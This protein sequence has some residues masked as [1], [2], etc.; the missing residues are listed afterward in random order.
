M[1]CEV[2]EL[3]GAVRGH[4]LFDFERDAF[5]TLEVELTGEFAENVEVVIGEIARNDRVFHEPGFTTFR[6][7]IF[8]LRNGR[9]RYRFPIA[10]HIPAYEGF[11]HCAAPAAAGGEVAPFRYV[12]INRYNGPATVRRTAWF[13]EWN[14]AACSFHSSCEVLNRIWDLCKYSIKATSLFGLYIDGERERMPYEADSYINELSHFCCDADYRLARATIDHF[15][16]HGNFTW[17]TEWLLI[18]PL[19]VREYALYSGDLDSVRQWLETMDEKLLPGYMDRDGLLA[20]AEFAE[21]DA[22]W[23]YTSDGRI[24]RAKIRDI[25]DW[26]QTE[27]DGYDFGT[28]NFVPNAFL[29]GALLTMAELTGKHEYLSRAAALRKAIRSHFMVQGRFVDSKGSVHTALHTAFFALRFGLAEP[30][31]EEAL[32]ALIKE[33]KLACSVYGAQFLLESCYMHDMADY[34][35]ELLTSDAVR[36]W[37]NM[38]RK[39]ATITLESWGDCALSTQ[40]WNHAWGAAPANLIMRYLC[41]IRPVK[42]GFAEWVFE[43]QPAGIDALECRQMTR[44]GAIELKITKDAMELTV[45]PGTTA[46]HGGKRLEP[47]VHK[48]P[49]Q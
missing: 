34:A 23:Y 19:L 30:E 11:P 38:L 43:P 13:G 37:Q 5:S 39:G 40:D 36:S 17:P 47:G 15:M 12:E 22:N 35:L 41:G 33:R 46:L 44:H 27:R 42:P 26:P 9:H 7:H 21:T 48:L 49:R 16:R 4:R 1:P 32:K 3:S 8:K 29:Y 28:V 10:T 6:Q 25:V 45:P 24:D 18:T 20:V 14:D 31:E 2:L